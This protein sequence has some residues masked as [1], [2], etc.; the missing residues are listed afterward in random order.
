METCGKSPQF[1]FAA[2]SGTECGGNVV[3]GKSVLAERMRGDRI[4]AHVETRKGWR[5]GE[6]AHDCHASGG[7]FAGVWGES[8]SP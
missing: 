2:R 5:I 7:K 3:Q 1:G 6:S 4:A 8:P